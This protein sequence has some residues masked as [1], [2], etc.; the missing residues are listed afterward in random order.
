MLDQR[1]TSALNYR[2]KPRQARHTTAA[3]RAPR[4][5]TRSGNREPQSFSTRGVVRPKPISRSRHFE[6]ELSRI[7]P[8]YISIE[9]FGEIC[10]CFRKNLCSHGMQG[11]INKAECVRACHP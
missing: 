8:H 7:P 2:Q 1:Y 10:K 11:L 9:D 3:K 4:T 6:R 5:Q